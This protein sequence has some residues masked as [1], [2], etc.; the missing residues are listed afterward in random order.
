MLASQRL[1]QFLVAVMLL[2]EVL[3][4][5]NGQPVLI[6]PSLSGSP[7]G[8]ENP[9]DPKTPGEPVA[10]KRAENAQH[11]QVAL[12]KLETGG[13]A[14][15]AAA[16]EVAYYQTREAVLTQQEAVEQQI[17]DLEARKAE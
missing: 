8:P 12:R 13:A 11:L 2:L 15:S 9:A 5:A 6:G 10:D 17:K 7:V 3:G 14:D 4:A 16:H 1:A